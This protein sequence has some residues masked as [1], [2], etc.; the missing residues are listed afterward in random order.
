MTNVVAGADLVPTKTHTGGTFVGGQAYDFRLGVSNAGD[1][2]TTGTVTVVDEFD[3]TQ[4]SSVNSASGT[5]WDCSPAGQTVTCTRSDPL[6]GGRPYP[7]IIV[8]A[9]VADPVPATVIN[10]ATV[11]GG[12]DVDD[13]N[14]S[15]TDAGGAVAQADLSISKFSDQDVVPARGEITYT[16]E[17][18][19]RGPSTATAVV[20]SDALA[21]N[22]EAIEVS[23]DRGSCTDAVVC[24]IGVLAPG[25]RATLTIRARVLDAAVESTV[26]NV[27]TITDTG[28]S[29]DPAADNNRAEVDVDVP[30]SSDLRVDKSFAPTPNPSAG[31]L[32]TYTVTVTNEGPSTATNVLTGDVLPEEFYVAGE[33]P[34]ATY[35]GGGSCAWLPTPRIVRCA[36]DE[37]DPGQT[38]TITITA[39]LRPDSRGTTVVNSIAA[40]SDSV[41]PNPGLATDTVSFVPIPA[42]DLELT[43]V[44]PPDPVQPGGLGRY[45]FQ[46]VNRGPSNAPDVILRDTLP[47]GLSFVGDTAGACSASGQAVTCALGPLDAGASGELGVDVRVDPSLAGETVRNAASI[48]A[49]PSDPNLAPAEVV[50]SSNSD[51]ADLVVAPLPDSDP[52]PTTPSPTT[53]LPTTPL[54]TTPAP[55]TP[56]PPGAQPRMI[57]EKSVRGS[58]ARVGDEL[59]WTV[60]VRNTGNAPARD[61]TVTDTPSAGLSPVGARPS[62]GTCSGTAPVRCS[63]GDLAA[64]ATAEVELRTRATRKGSVANAAQAASPTPSAAG[65]VLEA[66]ATATV[67]GADVRLSKTSAR[68]RAGAG[69][70]VTFALTARSRARVTVSGVRVC[71]RL[72]DGLAFVAAPGARYRAGQACWTL[73]LRPGQARRLT[74]TTRADELARTRRIRNTA[75]L[76]GPTVASRSAR[77]AVTIRGLAGPT[78]RCTAVARCGRWRGA[79]D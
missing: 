8:N 55:T 60:R 68:A 26:T 19:N 63:L 37:L 56:A 78:A 33:V 57:V 6:P 77:A 31:D 20:V 45:T 50:P 42:A 9:T 66:R 49:E 24:S 34:T 7:P 29:D 13:T 25:Q 52:E 17:A 41:D 27:A 67:R 32:V 76:R 4:F 22:F 30:V 44:G 38:E 1:V 79:F 2:P 75:V 65:A 54:P 61:V 39:R 62:A 64:G 72:P 5:G 43:K 53:P 16:L 70:R 3:A 36:I 59:V 69:D 28:A 48:A 73:R 35:T 23:S 18:V 51:A 71:D 58:G 14:N 74:L 10:T 15:A 11:T 40:I 21:S 12:G 47:D 46:F